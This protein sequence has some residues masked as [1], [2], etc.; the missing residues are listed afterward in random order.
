MTPQPHGETASEVALG[1]LV[2]IYVPLRFA[3]TGPPVGAFEIYLSYRPIAVALSGDKR[4]IAIVVVVGLALLWAVLY[5]IVASAS[6]RLR[7]Q[8]RDNYVLARYDQL[9]GLPNRTMF[10]ERASVALN[11]VEGCRDTARTRGKAL[12][13]AD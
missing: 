6:R 7:R 5:R 11:D 10:R 12:L 3:A 2:E 4:V 9:T 8:S 1:R 13:S